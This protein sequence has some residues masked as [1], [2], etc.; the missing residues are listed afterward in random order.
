MSLYS[1]PVVN[2]FDVMP[3]ASRSDIRH[4]RFTPTF[5]D[6]AVKITLTNVYASG[7]TVGQRCLGPI[8]GALFAAGD[9]L[10]R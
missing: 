8:N 3:R 5:A 1:I 2:R 6:I 4:A 10:C 9:S 7:L